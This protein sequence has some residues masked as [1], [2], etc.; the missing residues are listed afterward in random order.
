MRAFLATSPRRC[1]ELRSRITACATPPALTALYER[2]I[3]PH[4]VTSCRMLE[5]AGRQGG[6]N[7]IKT[8]YKLRK[9]IGD[10]DAEAVLTG[11]AAADELASLGL[12]TGLTRIARGEISRDEF[13]R[14]YGHRGPHEFELSLPR[15]GEDPGWIDEQLAGVRDLRTD[16]ATRLALQEKARDEAWARFAARYPRA[17]TRMR[18]RVRRWGGVVRDRETAR[19]ECIRAFWVLR[20]FVVRAGELT[21]VG[22]DVFYLHREELLDLLRGRTDA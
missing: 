12:I 11:V 20:A 17:T 6:A 19:S 3:E 21:G 9:M 14:R 15:P 5:A 10:A 7:L 8:R 1:E 16:P 18:E 22:D 13:A 4:V 2:E